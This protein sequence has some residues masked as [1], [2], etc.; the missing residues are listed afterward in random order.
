MTAFAED[1]ARRWEPFGVTEADF[2]AAPAGT[3]SGWSTSRRQRDGQ[4]AGAWWL[5]CAAVAVGVLAAA[6]AAV[7]W[8]AQY[9]MVWRVKQAAWVAALEA[10][11]PDIGAVVFAALGDGAGA[12]R[13]AGGAAAGAERWRASGSRW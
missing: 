2:A 8:Q 5:R 11:I 7:S 3:G 10:G 6:A 13:Q 1:R 4:R 9:M 12:A